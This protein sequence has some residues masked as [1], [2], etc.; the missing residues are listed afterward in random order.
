MKNKKGAS[1]SGEGDEKEVE[2][3]KEYGG[4]LKLEF[5]SGLLQ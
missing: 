3:W 2:R 1:L 5:G 4:N